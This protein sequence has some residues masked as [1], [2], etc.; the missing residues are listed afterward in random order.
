MVLSGCRVDVAIDV[1]VNGNGS[2]E[3]TVR[4]TADDEVV[5][6]APSLVD[7]LRFDDA[8]AQGWTVGETTATDDGGLEITMTYD[9][10]T[11]DEANVVLASLNGPSGPLQDVT[12]ARTEAGGSATISVS[13][14]LRVDGGLNAFADPALLATIGGATP[15]ADRIAAAGITPADA[16]GVTVAVD[17]GGGE[18]DYVVALDGSS[19]DIADAATRD[20]DDGASTPSGFWRLV[21]ALLLALLVGWI[22]ISLAFIVWVAR[23]RARRSRRRGGRPPQARIDVP[24]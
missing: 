5:Q 21:S 8:I 2:G 13:G 1:A 17:V 10:E 19:Q 11:V 3:I 7:D 14:A 6:Q 12:L 20:A 15:Y 18:R 23:Q 22:A 16:V 24:T 4:A 9:F